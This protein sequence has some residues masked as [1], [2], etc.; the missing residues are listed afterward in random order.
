MPAKTRKKPAIVR[1]AAKPAGTPRPV[2]PALTADPHTIA[3]A[4]R[5]LHL[6]VPVYGAEVIHDPEAGDKLELRLFGG[7]VATWAPAEPVSSGED[8]PGEEE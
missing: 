2:K 5:E 4:I 6:N 3:R 8:T 7:K 1:G